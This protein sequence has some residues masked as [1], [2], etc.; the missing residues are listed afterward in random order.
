MQHL[1]AITETGNLEFYNI[2][3]LNKCPECEDG[4]IKLTIYPSTGDVA[5]LLCGCQCTLWQFH[6]GDKRNIQKEIDTCSKHW[7]DKHKTS[8]ERG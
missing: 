4:D 8:R 5:G 6:I 3:D 2:P 7:N 1:K